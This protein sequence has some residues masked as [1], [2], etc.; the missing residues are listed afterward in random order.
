MR[1]D[2]CIEFFA[3]RDEPGLF[4]Q[5]P[6]SKDPDRNAWPIFAFFLGSRPRRTLFCR[7]SNTE[8]HRTARKKFAQPGCP[9]PTRRKRWLQ[10]PLMPAATARQAAPVARKEPVPGRWCFSPGLTS[11]TSSLTAVLARDA[12]CARAGLHVGCC[13]RAPFCIP[14]ILYF[15]VSCIPATAVF[16]HV[17]DKSVFSFHAVCIPCSL[18]HAY[19]IPTLCIP[20]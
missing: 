14:C 16:Q 1:R 9:P 17:N 11:L 3:E 8:K 12:I 13:G 6:N 10:E 18:H 15:F 20:H 19:C 5:K 2:A 4:W 7:F